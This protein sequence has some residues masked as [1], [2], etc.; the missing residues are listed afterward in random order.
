MLESAV[1]PRIHPMRLRIAKAFND[2]DYI[3][4]LK[5]DGF[6]ALAYVE[7]GKCKLVSR[8]SNLFKSF[9]SLKASLGKLRVQNAI[10][11]GEIICI[12]GHGISQFNQL[13]PRQGTPVFYAFDL[14]WLNHEDLRNVPLIE[15]KERLRELIDRN[16]PERII[17]AKH[18]E[19]EGKLLF[20]T[21][22]W[23]ELIGLTAPGERFGLA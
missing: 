10:L 4:E 12:D 22:I 18:V 21:F 6:R 7:E 23:A 15:R 19:R 11:D 16:K 9:E 17:Y 20:E 13:F 1:L 14:L 8:N 3:F 5:H 2:P